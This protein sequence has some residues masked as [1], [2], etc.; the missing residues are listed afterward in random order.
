MGIRERKLNYE[1]SCRQPLAEPPPPPT[2]ST[3]SSASAVER[4]RG[5]GASAEGGAARPHWTLASISEQRVLKAGVHCLREALAGD[6]AS[7]SELPRR[8]DG[9]PLVLQGSFIRRLLGDELELKVCSQCDVSAAQPDLRHL[10]TEQLLTLRARTLDFSTDSDSHSAHRNFLFSLDSHLFEK[11]ARQS[12][13]KPTESSQPA[14]PDSLRTLGIRMALVLGAVDV[15]A[16]GWNDNGVAGAEDGGA[17]LPVCWAIKLDESDWPG[18][19][20][21]VFHSRELWLEVVHDESHDF[22]KVASDSQVAVVT[23]RSIGSGID[24]RL[25][26]EIVAFDPATDDIVAELS[27]KEGVERDKLSSELSSVIRQRCSSRMEAL[28]LTPSDEAA[29]CP[30][31]APSTPAKTATVPGKVAD[32]VLRINK[33]TPPGARPPT[34]L[35]P[36]RW[37][38]NGASIPTPKGSG[39][40]EGGSAQSQAPPA[41]APTL[42][43]PLD[44]EPPAK[45]VDESDEVQGDSFLPCMCSRSPGKPN[46]LCSAVPECF[47]GI[48]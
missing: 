8:R 9:A 23:D 26:W 22:A 2:S 3:K 43:E 27:H 44:A 5:R 34:L 16:K 1:A 20:A 41:E 10:S 35:T 40:P 15:M 32:A 11:L 12:L 38:R 14:R 39:T 29:A 28:G 25:H 6:A 7:L 4:L 21:A 18:C 31:P 45:P 36:D 37:Q 48:F 47:K 42:D 19:S 17:S 46:V 30:S 33:A 24:R 13:R